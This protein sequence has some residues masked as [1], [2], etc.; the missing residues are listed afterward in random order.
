MRCA[1]T[2]VNGLCQTRDEDGLTRHVNDKPINVLPSRFG[3]FN[4]TNASALMRLGNKTE[5]TPQPTIRY[6][7]NMFM[8]IQW[9]V[10]TWV[11]SNKAG[12]V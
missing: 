2:S 9:A 7:R 8:K 6:I 3:V 12:A 1:H 10:T 11:Y 5:G 4:D